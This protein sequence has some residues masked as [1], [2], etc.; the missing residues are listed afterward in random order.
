M[1]LLV[2]VL[3]FLPGLKAIA[4][5][6]LVSRLWRRAASQA[7]PRELDM[8]DECPE[9]GSTAMAQLFERALGSVE[10]VRMPIDTGGHF[11]HQDLLFV[12]I[13]QQASALGEVSM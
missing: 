10:V 7:M 2:T 11:R 13:C 6:A 5:C 9:H 12:H 8:D 4:M 1:E 3:T